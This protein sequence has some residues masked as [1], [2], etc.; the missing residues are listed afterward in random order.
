MTKRLIGIGLAVMTT[1]LALVVF[2]QFRVVVIYVLISVT[3]AAALRPL[4]N[5]LTGRSVMV[6]IAWILLYLAV[7]GG[8]GFLLF[9]TGQNRGRVRFNCW[10]IQCRCRIPGC[11]RF[12]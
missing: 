5:R 1:L 4:V 12:G 7:L 9:L 6:R 2:W 3:L 11:C 8:F 10:R